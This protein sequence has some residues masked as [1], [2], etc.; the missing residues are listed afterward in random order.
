MSCFCWLSAASAACWDSHWSLRSAQHTFFTI[1]ISPCFMNVFSFLIYREG[2]TCSSYWTIM[3]AVAPPYS[4]FPS[5]SQ[6][7]L[8]GCT[9]SD[10]KQNCFHVNNVINAD[11]SD[12]PVPEG[13]E[14]FYNNITDMI[15]YR[16]NPFMKYCW[17]YITP[18]MCLVR[19]LSEISLPIR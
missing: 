5:A 10:F 14:R 4:S 16:L 19:I 12:Y 1:I 18:F 3:S 8:A 15:G 13:S 11:F 2:C 17:T 9:V 6:S 7:A